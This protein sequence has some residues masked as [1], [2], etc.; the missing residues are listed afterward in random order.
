MIL[1]G[2]HI[3]CSG[4]A[5]IIIVIIIVIIIIIIIVICITTIANKEASKKG[6]WELYVRGQSGRDSGGWT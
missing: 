2:E 1:G 5:I 6:E 3:T 4:L